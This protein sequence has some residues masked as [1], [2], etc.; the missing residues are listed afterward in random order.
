MIRYDLICPHGHAFEGWFSSSAAFDEQRDL[1]QIPCPICGA[2]NIDRAIMAPNVSTSRR[3]K[4]IADT[5]AKALERV[6]DVADKIR[7]HIT[8]TCEDVGANFAE[9][10]RAIHYGEKAERGIYG[11][12]TPEQAAAL[13]DEGVSAVALPDSLAPESKGKNKVH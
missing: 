7:R 10:A 3:Q 12:A 4:K 13:Q 11:R 2:V 8:E 1:G 5:Q 6:S 9:E